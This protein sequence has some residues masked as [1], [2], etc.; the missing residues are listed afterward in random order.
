LVLRNLDFLRDTEFVSF[1]EVVGDVAK[2]VVVHIAV[3][4]DFVFEEVQVLE[5]VLEGN[6]LVKGHSLVLRH[7]FDNAPDLFEIAVYFDTVHADDDRV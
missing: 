1:A 2:H 4:T 7:L 5:E 6:K 3:L